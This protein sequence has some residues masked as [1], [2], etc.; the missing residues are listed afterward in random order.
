M[1][2]ILF[3]RV[4]IVFV[5]AFAIALGLTPFAKWLAPKIGAIDMPKARGMHNKPMPRFGGLAIYL[6]SMIAMLLFLPLTG[7]RMLVGELV[8]Q[9]SRLFGLLAAGTVVFL[10]GVIDDIKGV[11]PKQKALGQVLGGLILFFSGIRFDFVGNPFV[12]GEI[13]EFHWII[14]LLL[15]VIWVVAITNT[16]NL[17][18]GLDGL[19]AGISFISAMCIAYVSYVHGWYLMCLILLALAGGAMGFLPW[20]FHPAKIFMGDSGALYLGFMLAAVSILNPAKQVTVFAMIMPMLVL[21]LPIFDTV[22]AI[23]RRA[24]NRQPLTM[25]DKGHL[26]HRIMRVGMGQKRTVLT[27]YS[28]CGIMGAAGIV[29]SRHLYYETIFLLGCAAILLYVFID[30]TSGKKGEAAKKAAEPA[31]TAPA[32][33]APAAEKEA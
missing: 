10:V 17:M 9:D 14:S 27:L 2:E 18:D 15:T 28:I 29:F 20:N 16:I 25:A 33:A 4:M 23:I 1:Q 26:H 6:G 3:I 31:E 22:F 21:A 13:I 7:D 19:A 32:E 5:V 8:E 11:T 24:V 12:P 30:D